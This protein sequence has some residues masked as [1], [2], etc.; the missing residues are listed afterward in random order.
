MGISQIAHRILTGYFSK[1]T[2]KKDLYF[3][4]ENEIHIF[5][6]HVKWKFLLSHSEFP[7]F[8]RVKFESFFH[9]KI[10]NYE[11]L[12]RNED[13]AKFFSTVTNEKSMLKVTVNFP[14]F[15]G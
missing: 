1:T 9:V 5:F 12:Y 4:Y 7:S 8:S 11:P 2:V 15:H 10:L 14:L 6:H 3:F 13:L